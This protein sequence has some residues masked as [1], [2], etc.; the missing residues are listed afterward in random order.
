MVIGFFYELMLL[1]L[2]MKLHKSYT[3]EEAQRALEHY[4]TYQDR[5]HLEV[6]TKLKSLRMIPEAQEIIIFHL[7]NENYLNEERFA[8]SY[9]R[10][11]FIIKQYGRIRIEIGL[12]QKQISPYLIK[13][14]LEEIDSNKYNETLI[15]LIEKKM[16]TI[17]EKNPYK[18]KKKIVDFL[19][20][21]GFEYN[22]IDTA[23]KDYIKF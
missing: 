17:P 13:K 20:R 16:E 7:L 12:K 6:M 2:R 15:A 9:S 1:L 22:L 19:L 10:G 23:I 8:K 4:C 14:G 21:R 3:V 11:K 5:C 18:K